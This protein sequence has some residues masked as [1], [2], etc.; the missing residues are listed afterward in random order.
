MYCWIRM[1]KSSK[2]KTLLSLGLSTFFETDLFFMLTIKIETLNKP[3][4]ILKVVRQYVSLVCLV[5]TVAPM[6]SQSKSIVLRV[7]LVKIPHIQSRVI[8]DITS[9]SLVKVHLTKYM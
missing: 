2:S 7:I 1:F 8:K 6:V 5:K 4:L 9:L 3:E